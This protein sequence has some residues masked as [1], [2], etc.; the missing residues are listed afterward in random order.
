MAVPSAPSSPQ[1]M[2]EVLVSDDDYTLYSDSGSVYSRSNASTRSFV[3]YNAHNE[4]PPFRLPKADGNKDVY[5]AW[6]IYLSSDYQEPVS[7]RKFCGIT[8]VKDYDS[9]KGSVSSISELYDQND[10][11]DMYLKSLDKYK[12]KHKR[13]WPSRLVRG[14]ARTYEDDIDS[15][16]RKLPQAVQSE[17]CRLLGDREDASS[18]RYHNRPW[19]V[20]MMQ[21]QLH[22]RFAD[23]NPKVIDKRHNVRFW[24]NPGKNEPTEYFVIIRGREGRRVPEPMGQ[25][26][27]KRFENPWHLA[28]AAEARHRTREHLDKL[29][30][31]RAKT[32]PP[33]SYRYS[34]PPPPPPP[35]FPKRGMYNAP[36]AYARPH[37][38]MP[39]YPSPGGP[40]APRM[41][42]PVSHGYPRPPTVPSP[43]VS[44]PPPPPVR[45]A[46]SASYYGGPIYPSSAPPPPPPPPRPSM[47]GPPPH[48][49]PPPPPRPGTDTFLPYSGPYTRIYCGGYYNGMQETCPATVQPVSAPTPRPGPGGSGTWSYADI[50]GADWSAGNPISGT[51]SVMRTACGPAGSVSSLGEELDGMSRLG[52]EV[53]GGYM[54]FCCNDDASETS[55]V[56]SWMSGDQKGDAGEAVQGKGKENWKLGEEAGVSAQQEDLR[57]KMNQ[58]IAENKRRVE[59]ARQVQEQTKSGEVEGSSV[60]SAGSSK[61][62]KQVKDDSS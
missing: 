14:T 52:K 33:P 7:V 1:M 47:Y 30:E 8:T 17:I 39:H 29:R 15:R 11:V 41:S 34:P 62:V 28:D 48:M 24:K 9:F 20:V 26:E 22:R 3:S 58:L 12:S 44:Y 42:H 5:E 31:K 10:L 56:R 45:Y 21:E 23:A 43:P 57:F 50:P 40:P 25:T 35:A 36:G 13:A 6:T 61:E 55:S 51:G 54:H 4:L 60:A 46:Q 16:I 53:D 59:Q 27:F 18:N 49:Q 32:V 2:K 38:G 19:T 37:I